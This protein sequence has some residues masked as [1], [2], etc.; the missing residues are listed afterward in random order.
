MDLIIIIYRYD[1]FFE[2]KLV[3]K[4][5]DFIIIYKFLNKT[6]KLFDSIWPIDNWE[7]NS[8]VC[9]M[10]F[11]CSCWLLNS[12]GI[13]VKLWFLH[14]SY[15]S[16]LTKT[17]QYQIQN[18]KFIHN[19]SSLPLLNNFD[20]HGLWLHFFVDCRFMTTFFFYSNGMTHRVAKFLCS[21]NT[22][23]VV[24]QM[25]TFLCFNVLN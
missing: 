22:Y 15:S 8:H 2:K 14:H 25:Y 12:I 6:Q 19:I 9:Y 5:L 7:I 1:I 23:D 13:I 4:L 21:A 11:F 20:M 3:N 16:L 24:F 17:V 10:K 18:V